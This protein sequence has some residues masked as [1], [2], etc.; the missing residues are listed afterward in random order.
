MHQICCGQSDANIRIPRYSSINCAFS[1][2]SLSLDSISNCAF[3]IETDSFNNPGNKLFQSCLQVFTGFTL[4][5]AAE[6]VIFVLSSFL[7]V[8]QR[9]FDVYGAKHWDYLWD[10]TKEIAESRTEKRGDFIDRIREIRQSGMLNENQVR[11]E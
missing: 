7:P 8:L 9:M 10:V 5:N 1:F 3:G 6:S 11:R 2:Q 4:H